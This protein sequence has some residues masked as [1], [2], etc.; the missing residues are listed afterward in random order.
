MDGLTILGVS[1]APLPIIEDDSSEGMQVGQD[2]LTDNSRN[3][4]LGLRM[5]LAT[6]PKVTSG[7]HAKGTS[8]NGSIV[9]HRHSRALLHEGILEA[10]F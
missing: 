7:D 5:L 9:Q 4:F 6:L 1:I 3:Q 8:T 10:R 2:I